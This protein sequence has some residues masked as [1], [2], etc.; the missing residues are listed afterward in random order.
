MAPVRRRLGH[1]ALGAGLTGVVL[2]DPEPLWVVGGLFVL[3]VPFE[4]LFPRHRQPLRRPGLG[5]DLAYALAQPVLTAVGLVLG[6]AVGVL[7]L[8]WLPG[9]ALRP[10]VTALP[11][12]PQLI[13]GVLL[14]DAAF[15]W[16]HRWSH[17]VPFLWRFH[18]VHHST[19]HLDWISGL[20]SHPVDG[21]LLGVPVAF[22]LGAGFTPEAAGVLAV[23]QIVFGLFIHANVR[24]RW[25]ALQRV[26]HTP[27]MHHWHH[28][29]EPASRNR[30]YA[31]LLPLW[32]QLFG[33]FYVPGDR[34]PE[35][36]GVSEPMPAGFLAQLWR[37]LRGLPSLRWVACRPFRALRRLGAA[38]ARGVRQVRLATTLRP[39]PTHTPT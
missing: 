22:L 9:L 38:L 17:E 1:A 30:N 39:R 27:E 37:P 34:R 21:A 3:V 32:D 13:L 2:V 33:T 6:A 10:L 26:V 35:A 29:D 7:S 23:L 11:P 25:R 16:V 5:T 24:W 12:G 36:Y 31:A 14:F 20:R 8:A 4:K 19:R 28:A 15:Y 18:A